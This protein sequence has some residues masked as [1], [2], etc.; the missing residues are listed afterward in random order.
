MWHKYQCAQALAQATKSM[1]LSLSYAVRYENCTEEEEQERLA[2][3]A[4]FFQFL[5]LYQ[6]DLAR[7]I[8][9]DGPEMHGFIRL[10]FAA[11]YQSTC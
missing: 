1:A 3:Q 8:G 4:M 7:E 2:T 11:N 5:A 6:D 9:I 10:F